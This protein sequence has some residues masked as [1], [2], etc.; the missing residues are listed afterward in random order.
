MASATSPTKAGWNFVFAAADQRRHRRITRHVGEAVEELVFRAEDY[1]GAED[2]RVLDR[3]EHG[4]LARRLGAEHRP[5]RE[6]ASAPIAEPSRQFR[7]DGLG[8][9]GDVPGAFMLHRR[10]KGLRA[11]LVEDAD[12]V[13]DVGRAFDRAVERPARADWPATGWIWPT[14]PSGCTWPASSGRRVAT[15]IR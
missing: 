13:D 7:A 14:L 2:H 11:G 4:L 15:R 5:E 6:V 10:K 9:L 3:L 1:G 12:E 8:G